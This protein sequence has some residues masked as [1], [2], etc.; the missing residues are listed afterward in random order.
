M[1]EMNKM[2]KGFGVNMEYDKRGFDGLLCEWC[3]EPVPVASGSAGYCPQCGHFTST[4][5]QT[6]RVRS[7]LNG[8]GFSRRTSVVRPA[9]WSFPVQ[10]AGWLIA[11]L[12]ERLVCRWKGDHD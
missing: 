8:A 4:E 1:P 7:C 5:R 9:G 12:N 10:T 6:V 11:W 2:G 3:G